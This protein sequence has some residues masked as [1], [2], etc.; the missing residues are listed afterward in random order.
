M[1]AVLDF[2]GSSATGGPKMPQAVEH[3]AR[4]HVDVTIVMPCLNEAKTLPICIPMAMEALEILRARMGLSGEVVV[5]DNGSTD[6]SQAIAESL[7]ARVVHCAERGYGAALTRGIL[8]AKGRLI[9]MGDA[10][11]SYDFREAVAMIAKLREGYDLC[12]G[13]RFK[14]EIKPGAMPWRNRRIGNPVLTGILN[15]F[16]RSGLS[17]AHCG[18]RGFTKA[19]FLRINPTSTGMEF[20]SEI[21]IKATLL[22]L[23]R[24]EVPVTLYPDGRDRAPHLRPWRDGWRHLRYLVMLSPLWLYFFPALALGAFGATILGLVLRAPAGGV[25]MV[26]RFWLG[27]HWAVLAGAFLAVALQTGLMGLAATL[28]GAREGYRVMTPLLRAVYW[29][30][31]LENMLVFGALLFAAGAATIGYVIWVWR[32][33]GYGGLQMVREMVLASTLVVMGLQTVLSGFLLSVV[34]GNEAQLDAAIAR[35]SPRD[36]S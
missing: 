8:G 22:G 24:T 7:E 9:V 12:M 3:A 15:S 5:A 14:G 33:G 1:G 19:A 21:V 26:G 28:Y 34:G 20:A 32:T 35:I 16:F 4:D 29:A 30:T 10:D 31:R 18:L 13:S 2:S 23:K 11:G 17:D 25:A 27:D 36:R 6:G